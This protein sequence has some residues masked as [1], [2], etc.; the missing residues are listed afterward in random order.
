MCRKEGFVNRIEHGENIARLLQPRD[1]VV[2]VHGEHSV[3]DR[4]AAIDR[5]RR[6]EAVAVTHGDTPT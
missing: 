5:L 6:G 4:R 1:D 3:A 2:F